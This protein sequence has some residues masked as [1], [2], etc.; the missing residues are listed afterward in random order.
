[1]TNRKLGR[2]SAHRNLMLRNMAT[3]LL[4]HGRIETT[5]AKAKEARRVTEKM[6]TLG[7]RD[8]LHAK[9]Q[10]LSYLMDETVVKQ[11]FDEIGPKYAERNGGYTRIMKKGPRR[12]DNSE[13][14]IIELV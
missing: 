3:D 2:D 5:L 13:M 14:A 6:I 1:M 12:G 8:D 7:K 10:A 11:L 4:R 9:R